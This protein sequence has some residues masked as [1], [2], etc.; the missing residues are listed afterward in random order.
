MTTTRRAPPARKTAPKRV[1]TGERAPRQA[2]PSEPPRKGHPALVPAVALLLVLAA[3]GA[4]VSG[5][6]KVRRVQVVGA[7]LPAT[8]IVQT[9]DVTGKNIFRLRSD[10]I[11]QRLQALPAV[12]VTR[13]ETRFPD[14]VTIYASLRHAYV[15]WRPGT[16][17]FLVDASGVILSSTTATT[18][19]LI[20]G[21]AGAPTPPFSVLQAARY[22]VKA[23]S[24]VP[25]GAVQESKMEPNV[26][27]VIIGRSGWQA[28][29]G[30]GDPQA[31]VSR[32]AT[33]ASLLRAIEG[34][35]QHLKYA[36]L[37]YREPYYHIK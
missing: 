2:T 34:R 30:S 8:A 22:A 10:A 36:D 27:M 6:F 18:L 26:G 19:P 28:V 12:D 32:V 29:I 15:A 14:T 4:M 24:A 23:L 31:L 16:I 13:V 9:A 11:V 21:T 17:T 1:G 33:L 5:T 3:L 20:V 37:R 7:G 25:D 35:G